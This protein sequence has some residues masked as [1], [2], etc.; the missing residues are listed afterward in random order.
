MSTLPDLVN[1]NKAVNPVADSRKV[2][3][4]TKS[5]YM[6]LGIKELNPID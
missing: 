4:P 6:V 2:T 3:T 1:P 5:V